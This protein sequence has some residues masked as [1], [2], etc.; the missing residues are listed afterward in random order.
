MK[1][2]LN[3]LK[4]HWKEDPKDMIYS[5]LFLIGWCAFTYFLLWFGSVF[6]Y[7]M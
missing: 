6:A 3:T 4:E 5:I 7:D 1:E 2:M